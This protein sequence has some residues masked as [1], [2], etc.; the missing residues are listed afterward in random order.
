MEFA[1][2]KF[3]HRVSYH[4]V[5]AG[6]RRRRSSPLPDTKPARRVLRRVLPKAAVVGRNVSSPPYTPYV[7]T[8]QRVVRS[9]PVVKRHSAS[10]EL[11]NRF[12]PSPPRLSCGSLPLPVRAAAHMNSI[13]ALLSDY[14][15]Q[16]EA[17]D[18]CV[19]GPVNIPMIQREFPD[20]NPLLLADHRL[21][22]LLNG[23]HSE[24]P[25]EG[26][27]DLIDELAS[28]RIVS[29]VPQYLLTF[30]SGLRH[31][32]RAH[33]TPGAEVSTQLATVRYA[34]AEA[35]AKLPSVFPS[36][37]E[38]EYFVALRI[39]IQR[40][41]PVEEFLVTY[42][43]RGPLAGGQAFYWSDVGSVRLPAYE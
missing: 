24:I 43:T 15:P 13:V 27:L 16:P 39:K 12:W 20:R 11:L 7:E 18:K 34:F 38:S 2:S 30:V 10:A 3:Q 31:H 41:C 25:E 29:V 9:D 17:Q 4:P 40:P 36:L 1:G 14:S 23:I 28:C 22:K 32:A 21:T 19:R 8:V 5:A 33:S 6:P 42:P 26:V 35:C 37:S